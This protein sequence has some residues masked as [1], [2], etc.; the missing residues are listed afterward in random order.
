M[1]EENNKLNY[2]KNKNV[3]LSKDAIERMTVQTTDS[4]WFTHIW[5]RIYI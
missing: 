2:L 4:L 1:K 5:Q 3:W